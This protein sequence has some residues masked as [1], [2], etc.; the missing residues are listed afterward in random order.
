MVS[1]D[2]VFVTDHAICVP[3]RTIFCVHGKCLSIAKHCV[4]KL[5]T[6]IFVK[7]IHILATVMRWINK[8]LF[9]MVIITS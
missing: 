9:R 3:Y 6:P 7:K 1:V 2:K 5:I 4:H 8:T